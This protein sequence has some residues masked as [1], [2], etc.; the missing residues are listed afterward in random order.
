M[1]QQEQLLARAGG[2]P[3]KIGKVFLVLNE[4]PYRED[5]LRDWKYGSTHFFTSAL[6]RYECSALRSDRFTLGE[7]VPC[8]HWI[9]GWVGP[10]AGLDAVAKRKKH[11]IIIPVGNWTQVG[12]PVA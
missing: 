4:V 6:D 11:S 2:T 12:Q 3:P 10:R 1:Q 8:T 9:G 5:V 7:R